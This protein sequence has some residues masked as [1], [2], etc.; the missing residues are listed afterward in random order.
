MHFTTVGYWWFDQ[1]NNKGTLNVEVVK[2]CDWRFELSVWG[3][4]LI[5]ILYCWLFSVTTEE[6]DEFDAYYEQC[7]IDDS[8]SKEKEPGHDPKCPYHWGHM[9]GVCWEYICVYG[10]FASWKKY[11]AECNRIMDI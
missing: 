8:I 9:A 6:A 2:M 11:E 7:Y 5:E 4:E 3:H 1:P 10:T